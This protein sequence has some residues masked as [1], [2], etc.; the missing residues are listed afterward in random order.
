MLSDGSVRLIWSDPTPSLHPRPRPRP[1]PHLVPNLNPN[2][3]PHPSPNPNQAVVVTTARYQTP[4]RH[5]INQIGLFPDIKRECELGSP[6][7]ECLGD[8]P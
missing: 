3:S 8:V 7:L 2:P 6:A 4:L 1:S 5:N